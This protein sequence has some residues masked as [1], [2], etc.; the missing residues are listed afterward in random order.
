MTSFYLSVR[1]NLTVVLLLLS[2]AAWA[3]ERTVSGKVTSADDGSGVPGVNVLEKGTSNGTTTDMDGNFR[4]NVSSEN[5]VLSFSFI[6]YTTQEVTVGAQTVINVSLASDITTLSEVVVVG[7]GQQEKRDVTGVVAEVKS[8]SF[9][10]GSILSPDQLIAGKI[11]GVSITPNSGEPGVGGTVRIRG[12]TSINAS[13]DPLYVIDGVPL[14]T[15]GIPGI[16]NVPGSRNPL[17]FINPNDIETFTVLKDASA[18]AIYGSRAANGVII[19]TTKR[20]KAGETKVT[21]DGFVSQSEITRKLNLLD[22]PQF[23]EVVD[24]YFP[25]KTPLLYDNDASITNKTNTNWQDQMLRTAMGQSHNIGITGG[26]DK[27]QIRASLGYL[28][29]DGIIKNS[30]SKRTSFAL[31]LDNKMLNDKLKIQVNVKGSETK[32][33]YNS[34]SIG[35]T[36]DFAPS[37]PVYDTAK[38]PLYG[39]YWEW[40]SVPLGT[41]N[42]VADNTLSTNFGT[43][44]RGLGNMKFDYDFSDWVPGLTSTLNLGIDITSAQRN[45]FAPSYLRSQAVQSFPGN[46]QNETVQRIN[47]LLEFYVNY[48]KTISSIDAKFDVTGGYSYQN[49]ASTDN[50]YTGS[51]T[52]TDV[53]GINN[54]SV[55]TGKREIYANNLTNRL[56][57]FFGRVNFSVKDKYL[58]TVNMR[59][60]GST[61]FGSSNRWGF[62]PSVALGWRIYDEDFFSSLQDVFSDLKLRAS[63]GINGNQEIPNYLYLTTYGTTNGFAEYPFGTGFASPIRPVAVDPNLKWEETSSLNV[64]LDFGLLKGRLTG[65]IEIYNKDTKDLLFTKNVPGGTNVGDQVLTNV[66]K[67]NNNGFELTL[68]GVAIDRGDMHWD[69]GLN[70]SMNVNKVT[71]LDGV[72][73]P[74]FQGYPAGFISGGI[75]NSVQVLKVGYPINTFRLYQHKTG[76]DGKPLVDGVDWNN[77]GVVD[78][79][80]MYVDVNGDGIVSD[81]DR[82]PNALAYPA[83]KAQLGLTSNFTWKNIDFTFTLRSNMGGQV[84]NNV[85]SS[86][87]YL[88]RII[89][90]VPQN[91]TTATL[92][93]NFRS[94]QYLSNYYLEDATF[95]RV[96]NITLGYTVKQVKNARIRVYATIQNAFVWS[97]YT[98]LDPEVLNGI[99]NNLYPRSRTYVFGLSIGL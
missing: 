26:T 42:P 11:A 49:F 87:G 32:D 69:L 31:G 14:E 58:L 44:Y 57:S 83:P 7:Y 45:Y 33:S 37:Q 2:L 62:F 51:G 30:G 10:K 9:N 15:T 22:G 43:S 39:G 61:R 70:F 27:T 34:G 73:D 5:S 82:Q 23:R 21:Y 97:N 91:V 13:N 63:Y 36:Y 60:D 71:A 67:V 19:I 84:Y 90:L 28:N 76:A 12:G 59:Q 41:K 52:T 65:S 89:E 98:G 94:P 8:T 92:N 88:N 38:A 16:N 48:S 79:K 85:Q 56:I 93:A 25:S 1:R 74:G 6:G 75:G 95:I 99:D 17:N 4:I 64:G 72:D 68:N 81:L 18:A 29:Q 35:T 55:A 54:P 50:G 86:K 47:K 80:D 96:D 66:G 78:L 3:Q 24:L 53:F 40:G 46:V 77:D 20:G